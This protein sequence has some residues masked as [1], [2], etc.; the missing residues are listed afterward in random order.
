MLSDLLLERQKE[1]NQLEEENSKLEKTV[2][3]KELDNMFLKS[4]NEILSMKLSNL[5]TSIEHYQKIAEIKGKFYPTKDV[6]DALLYAMKKSHP[7]NGG[8]E[9]DFIRFKNCY[10]ELTR[11]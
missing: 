1:I 9:E 2:A 4:D 11:K 7:D 6:K 5:E 3:R 8:K 10:E